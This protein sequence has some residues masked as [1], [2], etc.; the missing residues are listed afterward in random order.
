MKSSARYQARTK[1]FTSSPLV[2]QRRIGCR[3]H[4]GDEPRL[5]GAGQQD[6]AVLRLGALAEGGLP[7]D[8]GIDL[9]CRE[10]D[11]CVGRRHVDG[12]DVALAH[13]CV[14][15]QRIEEELRYRALLEGHLLALEA[16][17]RGDVLGGD[18]A[19]AALG[20]V[21]RHHIAEPIPGFM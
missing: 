7:G 18:D 17:D 5:V 20:I 1:A 21:D 13:A 6:V 15:E 8:G 16:F 9:A 14:L 3:H 4:V 10:G 19:V 2:L 11:A 12:L